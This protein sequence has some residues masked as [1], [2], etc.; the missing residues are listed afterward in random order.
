MNNTNNIPLDL[1]NDLAY[2]ITKARAI[3][4]TVTT[5]YCEYANVDPFSKDEAERE[6]AYYLCARYKIWS[7]LLNCA[8]DLLQEAETT[9]ESLVDKLDELQ[10]KA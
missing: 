7:V 5:E 2:L 8:F 3:C 1:S 6:R 4:E 9:A 10:L